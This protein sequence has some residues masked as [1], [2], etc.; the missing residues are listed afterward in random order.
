M[1][2]NPRYKQ[3]SF[4]KQDVGA[5][6]AV[7]IYIA[8]AFL[9]FQ[10]WTFLSENADA[11]V[12]DVQRINGPELARPTDWRAPIANEAQSLD[13]ETIKRDSDQNIDSLPPIA[14]GMAIAS[15]CEEMKMMLPE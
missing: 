2:Y 5:L 10:T 6:V 8:L 4:W 11:F 14:C 15:D 12:S 13:D 9:V 3:T 1:R 7:A